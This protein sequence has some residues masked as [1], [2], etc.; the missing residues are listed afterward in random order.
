[1]TALSVP[2]QEDEAFG[3]YQIEALA[4]GV[5]LVQPNSGGFPEFIKRTDGGILYS[6][7]NAKELAKALTQVIA[8]PERIHQMSKN[9]YKAVREHFSIERMAEKMINVYEKYAVSP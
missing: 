9:G 2:V 8:N 1:M 5:P 6:P 4:A 3:A 7:N